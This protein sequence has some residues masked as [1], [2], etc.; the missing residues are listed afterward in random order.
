MKYIRSLLPDQTLIMKGGY[1]ELAPGQCKPIS[2]DDLN[3]VSVFMALKSGQA[4]ILEGPVGPFVQAAPVARI[5]ISEPEIAK[6]LS[7][8]ELVSFLASK[9]DGSRQASS[10]LP[11]VV[12]TVPPA[13]EPDS[14]VADLPAGD[15][16]VVVDEVVAEPVTSVD[17]TFEQGSAEPPKA[18]RGRRA[19]APD[20]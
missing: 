4:E 12:D 16:E 5:V 8:E 1:I 14:P 20:A 17:P 13:G 19:A 18:K 7:A 11:A 9:Q 15:P 2:D 3:N 10:D 6:S